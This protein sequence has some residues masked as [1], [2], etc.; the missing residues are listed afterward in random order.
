MR[1]GR[2]AAAT[3][4]WITCLAGHVVGAA[5]PAETDQVQVEPLQCWRDVGSDAVRVGEPFTMRVTCAVIET[6]AATTV[7][8]EVALAPETID[9]SPFE[10][11]GGQRFPDVRDG[12]WRYFQYQY[13]LR[14]ID[15]HLFG[16]NVEVPPLELQYHIERSLDG[17]SALPGRELRYVL[18]PH[19]IRVVSLVPQNAEDIREPAGDTFGDADARLF[20]AN[21]A[22]L[23]ASALGIVAVGFLIL[24][25][26]RLRRAWRGNA[27]KSEKLSIPDS[28]VVRRALAE[29]TALQNSTQEQGWNPT[30]VGR[31]LA[32]FRLAGA[33]ALSTPVAQEPVRSGRA[34]REGQLTVRRGLWRPK[35]TA[36]SASVTARSVARE[37]D[38]R[39]QLN[40]DD[41][42]L[43]LLD[44]LQE[45]FH[46]FTVA[47]YTPT[48]AMPSDQMTSD[49]DRGIG[50][51]RQLRLRT[52]APVQ[53]TTRLI[54]STRG[55]WSDVWA[56]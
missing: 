10:V 53:H 15:E 27:P 47:R 45:A 1:L 3:A 13:T 6:A 36:L 33:A 14:I 37:I 5:Q 23:V 25:L 49:L 19:P 4:I 46:T 52:W 48:G 29:L 32:A 50:A 54:E 44:G 28:V 56:R 43:G 18:P 12:P 8:N 55:W 7:P 51:V 34:D 2:P 31:A 16:E 42:S 40:P 35:T 41:S 11:I 39:R 21:L 24:A 17:G 38:H 30:L 9:V 26:L 22:G 20:R